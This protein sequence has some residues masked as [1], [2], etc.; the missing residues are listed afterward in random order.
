LSF[1]DFTRLTS[2][3]SSRTHSTSPCTR[4]FICRSGLCGSRLHKTQ[5][6]HL[7]MDPLR[8]DN[9]DLPF[10]T[11]RYT[12]TTTDDVQKL[13]Q[14]HHDAMTMLPPGAA[15]VHTTTSILPPPVGLG[16]YRDDHTSQFP[17]P[18][19]TDSP[20]DGSGTSLYDPS[21][22]TG[23]STSPTPH[24]SHVYPSRRPYHSK[25]WFPWRV[26]RLR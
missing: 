12:S 18:L 19:S 23:D 11:L 6:S 15:S 1:Y 17:T 5:R 26:P 3:Q 9:Q 25:S 14:T 22:S 8:V 7:P 20:N 24:L 4:S 16:H 13:Y 2:V 10:D 21:T